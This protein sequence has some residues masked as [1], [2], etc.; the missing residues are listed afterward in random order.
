L[1]KTKQKKKQALSSM[2]QHKVKEVDNSYS[3]RSEDARVEW[4]K[5]KQAETYVKR[6]VIQHLLIK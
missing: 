4:K 2:P 6:I 5:K 3:L 1:K